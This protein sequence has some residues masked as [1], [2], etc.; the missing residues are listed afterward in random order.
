ML[1]RHDGK[2]TGWAAAIVAWSVAGLFMP[3]MLCGQPVSSPELARLFDEAWQDELRRDPLLATR[4]GEKR[5]NGELPQ[6]SLAAQEER[7]EAKRRFLQR[8]EAIDPNTLSETDRVHW[9]IFVRLLRDDL[10]EGAFRGY[11]LA[12]T[13]RSGFYIDFPDL[14]QWV[15]LA[16]VQDYR[17]YLSRLRQFGRYAEENIELLREGIRQKMV[18]PAVVLE[19]VEDVIRSPISE[20]PRDTPWFAPFRAFPASVP[21]GIR[22]DLAHEAEEAIRQVV[23]PAYRKILDFMKS[24]YLPA[25]RAS[26][27]ASDLPNGRDY[28]R[29]RVQMFSTLDITPEEIHEIGLQ[30]VRRIRAE[31]EAVP[32]RIGFQGSY[33]QFV[34]HLRTDP[35]Y[36]AATKEQLL[37]E[38]SYVLK[39]VDG[40]LPRWFGRL[41]RMPYGIREVPEHIAPRTTTAY[42]MQPAGDGT[43]AGFYYV[44]TYNLKSRPLYEIEALSLHEAVPGHHLQIALAQE[45]EDMPAFRR[46]AEPTAFV[47]GW[48]LYAERLG[49]EMGF[50]QDPISDFG[51]LSYEMWRACRLVVDTGIH[52]FGWSRRQAIDFMLEN[53]ALSRH[54]IEAEVDRYISWPGQAVAY[55]IGELTIR[56]LRKEAE[57]ALKERFDIRRFH[58]VVLGSGAVPLDVLEE[59][60]RRYI[61]E[62]SSR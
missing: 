24:E 4:V 50:Y 3:A 16:T 56:R 54:N 6:V 23:V 38:V 20:N 62:T 39:R 2:L 59:N 55:K 30:E 13:N 10:T 12:I 14:P 19:G 44:N 53:T 22:D 43:R 52:Y 11:L 26:V 33:Q 21:S 49:Q 28:Y 61:Q 47:E 5:W 1:I 60:V 27:G 18:L 9:K 51:R 36:Y 42:Y 37:K 57:E 17:D 7:L 15:P 45:L 46:F 29:H 31:M 58:D 48:A 40:E 8:A 25:A 41:P 35:K 34:E 32:S